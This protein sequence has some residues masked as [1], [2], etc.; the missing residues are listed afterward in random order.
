[1]IV[2]LLMT[3][4]TISALASC[5]RMSR[6]SSKPSRR[7]KPRLRRRGSG[8]R[9]R[10]KPQGQGRA[11]R[12]VQRSRRRRDQPGRLQG[13]AGAGQSLGHLVRA[14]RQGIADARQAAGSH[15]DDGQLGVIAVS[16]DS[17]P[18]RRSVRS[19]TFKIEDLG[20]YQDS[21][22]GAVRRAWA[23]SPADHHP[24]R[25]AGQGS[26]ALCRRPRLDQPRS[27]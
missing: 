12:H 5:G 7:G 15:R 8:Q 11:R 16:Q 17:G 19:S 9:R 13:Q 24:L 6:P 1:M 25:R 3:V 21:E 10:P 14:L 4:L 2:R 18:H 22:D 20:G 23:G 26:L 27:G